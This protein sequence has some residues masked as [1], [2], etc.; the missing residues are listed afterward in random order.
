MRRTA[1]ILRGLGLVVW[2]YG[3]MAAMGLVL[4]PVAA[5]G[6]R[7]WTRAFV[8]LYVRLVLVGA[9][10][11]C[12]LRTEIR[13]TPPRGPALIAAKHQSFLDILMLISALERPRFVMK[14]SL[15]WAP[16][17][18]FY[19]RRIGCVA[20]DRSRGREAMAAMLA[21]QATETEADGQ[22]VIYPQGTRVAPGARVSWKW[23]VAGLYEAAGGP[24]TPVATNAGAFWPRKGV[25]RWP[26]TAVLEFL[27]E[28]EPGLDAPAFMARL[29][30]EVETAS[31]AL[32]AEA[33]RA[34]D[35]D[36]PTARG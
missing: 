30:R 29:E 31:D 27:P 10:L 16:V 33:L 9:R 19:A 1:A 7:A 4:A 14:R 34:R 2:T 35:Q 5:L 8:R 17:L 22:L 20:I 12:G 6:P 3:L 36:A 13:G 15:L 21:A 18:G 32:L 23:G 11:I 26:G 24:C 25:A 28:I